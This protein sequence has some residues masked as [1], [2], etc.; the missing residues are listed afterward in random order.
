MSLIETFPEFIISSH[1]HPVQ[2]QLK[3]VQEDKEESAGGFLRVLNWRE[4]A[5]NATYLCWTKK[6]SHVKADERTVSKT[7]DIKQ[8]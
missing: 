4:M 5:R 1:L 2:M 7:K 6:I 3:T 8:L